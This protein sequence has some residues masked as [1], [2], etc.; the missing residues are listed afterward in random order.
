MCRRELLLL[1]GLMLSMRVLVTPSWCRLLLINSSLIQATSLLLETL[2]LLFKNLIDLAID[3]ADLHV[4]RCR[5]GFLNNWSFVVQVVRGPA[6]SH[7]QDFLLNGL[8][9]VVTLAGASES[10]A[11]LKG[12]VPV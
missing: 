6:Q 9:R 1:L 10:A 2:V 4:L 3:E 12:S 7:V 11:G 8:Q 5:F